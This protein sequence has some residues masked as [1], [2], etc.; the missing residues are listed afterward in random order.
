M[1]KEGLADIIWVISALAAGGI[2][3]WGLFHFLNSLREKEKANKALKES[4]A[5][6]RLLLKSIMSPVLA[7]KND[8]TVFYCNDDFTKLFNKKPDDL[9]GKNILV[10]YPEFARNWFYDSLIETM[11]TG[12]PGKSEGKINNRYWI[13]WFNRTQWGILAIAKDITDRKLAEIEKEKV[14]RAQKMQAIGT[15]AGGIAHDFNNLLTA[16]Q[17]YNELAMLT[18]EEN[19]ELQENLKQIGFAVQNAASLTR[20]LLFFSREKPA[21]SVQMDINTV[22][23]NLLNMLGRLI[24]ENIKIE[25]HLDPELRTIHADEGSIKQVIMNLVVNARDSM[26]DGGNISIKTENL[27]FTEED[28]IIFPDSRPGKFIRLT[29]CD[30]GQGMEDYVLD[31]IFEPFFTTKEPGKGTGLGLAVVYGI[32]KQH[33][34]WINV[35]S[36]LEKGTVF[37]IYFPAYE[38]ESD[39]EQKQFHD[40]SDFKGKNERILFVEDDTGVRGFVS[41]ALRKNGYTVFEATNGDEAL[42]IYDEEGGD[43]KLLII[44][45]ILPDRNG[46]QLFKI[47]KDRN[48]E[49]E[50]LFCSGYPD[51]RTQLDEAYDKGYR[52]IQKPF[53]LLYLLQKV[54][55]AIESNAGS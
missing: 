46:L 13:F 24:G 10:A 40:L 47:L 19:T 29:V 28:H 17:G 5:R 38:E 9:Q 37:K 6:H 8:M 14:L 55:S 33:D 27:I 49:L 20:Q 12:K 50:A 34:G 39:I 32:I 30:N 16:I 21:K 22:I 45:I 43:F 26:I 25:T 23:E 31:H 51:Q 7:L 1:V 52:Y 4:E 44:D 3:S 35:S 11:E 15:L 54:R 36:E 41:K 42:R 48:P 2:L 53:T 18:S